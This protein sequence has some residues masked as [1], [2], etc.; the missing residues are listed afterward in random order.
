MRFFVSYFIKFL[1]LIFYFFYILFYRWVGTPVL[2]LPE[3]TMA[4]RTCASLIRSSGLEHELV[5]QSLED[6]E[7]KAVNYAQDSEKLYKIRKHLE[8]TRETSALFDSKRWVKNFEDGI[9]LIWKRH[10]KGL[11][12]DHIV[13]QDNEP[14]FKKST[15]IF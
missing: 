6:Y 12:P 10:E 2:T 15:S 4:S 5:A 8:D 11:E 14:I 13:V 1:F 9:N 7:E 3:E